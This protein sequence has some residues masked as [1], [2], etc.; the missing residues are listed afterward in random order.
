MVG[1]QAVS[2]CFPNHFFVILGANTIIKGKNALFFTNIWHFTLIALYIALTMARL[3]K[4]RELYLCWDTAAHG[5]WQHGHC[6]CCFLY[7]LYMLFN[8]WSISFCGRSSS[9]RSTSKRRESCSWSW[10]WYCTMSVSVDGN[11]RYL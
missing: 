7:F 1:T 6:G 8:W 4:I 2:A 3:A 11:P 5:G 9:L 10:V